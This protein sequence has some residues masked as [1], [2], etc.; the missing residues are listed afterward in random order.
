[1]TPVKCL[2]LVDAVAKAGTVEEIHT[3]CCVL[4]EQFGF[5][6][7]IYGTRIPTSFVNPHMFIISGYPIEWRERYVANDYLKIDPTVSCCAR[8]LTPLPWDA[9]RPM[10]REN[11]TARAFMAESR[12]FGLKSGV[13]FP[14]HSA[15]GEFAM[16]SLVSGEEPDGAKDRIREATSYA[17]LISLHIHEAVRRAVNVVEICPGKVRLSERET[18]CLL[19]TAEGKTSWETSKILGISERTVIF[20]L[21][22]STEKLKVVNRQQAIARAVSMGL[23]NPQL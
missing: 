9:M 8:Q 12:E 22:N 7:F 6:H 1:M 18:E 15:Q 20:H 19:W 5:D 23:I 14:I 16:L 11:E 17:H 4:C 2:E 10:E 21:Q 13:S 3:L